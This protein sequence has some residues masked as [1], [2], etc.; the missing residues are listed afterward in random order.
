MTIEARDIH[1][2]LLR[3]SEFAAAYLN[4]ALKEGDEADI[5]M[6]LRRIA[7]VQRQ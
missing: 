3:D 5:V 4:I 7:D 6:A 2:E 1:D